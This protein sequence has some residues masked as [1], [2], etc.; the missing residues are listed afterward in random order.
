MTAHSTECS[1]LDVGS[2]V[3]QQCRLIIE[4][5]FQLLDSSVELS[6]EGRCGGFQYLGNL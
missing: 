2:K 3:E 1:V 4:V 5:V 6:V